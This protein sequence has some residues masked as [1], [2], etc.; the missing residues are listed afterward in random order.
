MINRGYSVVHSKLSVKVDT[1]ENKVSGSV[2]LDVQLQ[3][4][5]IEFSELYFHFRCGQV[6]NVLVDG[7]DAVFEQLEFFDQVGEIDF[8]I[9]LLIN[10]H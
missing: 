9:Y 2:V 8:I 7:K 6:C 4:R 5:S 10:C 3:D 1:L